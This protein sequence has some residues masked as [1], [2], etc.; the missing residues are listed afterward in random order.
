VKWR[1]TPIASIQLKAQLPV[2]AFDS[3]FPCGVTT[4]NAA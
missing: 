1:S 2:A 4:I 3:I